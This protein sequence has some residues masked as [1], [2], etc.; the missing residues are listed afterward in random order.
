MSAGMESRH[1]SGPSGHV[2]SSMMGAMIAM[3]EDEQFWPTVIDVAT[4]P[5]IIDHPPPSTPV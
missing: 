5:S 2:F 1:F 3:M 4:A